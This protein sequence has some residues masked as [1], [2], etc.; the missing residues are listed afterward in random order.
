VRILV[1]GAS[2]MLGGRL[3]QLLSQRH[4]VIAGRHVSASPVGL[5]AVALELRSP[6]SLARALAESRAEAVVHAAACADADLCQREPETAR[7][8]NRAATETLAGLCLERRVRLIG[9]STDLVLSGERPLGDE[10]QPAEPILEYGR[11]KLAAEQAVLQASSDFAVLRVALVLGRGFG[12]RST[13]SEGLAW[14]WRAS[15]RTPLFT[16][17]FRTPIDAESVA[18]AALRVLEGR[19]SGLFQIGGAERL[20]RHQLGL[21]TSAALGLDAGL[22]DA[23]RQADQPIGFPRP[24]DCS[25]HVGRAR[26]E[27]GWQPRPLDVA[28]RESRLSPG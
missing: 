26:R 23:T 11:S 7:Q 21:R 6:D 19:G 18:D 8:L 10:T 12:P 13:A 16:D 25:M 2:G 20:S 14:A 24:A 17:Q 4:E 1:S 27:L 22:I 15:R 9:L 28:L 3:A 5:P